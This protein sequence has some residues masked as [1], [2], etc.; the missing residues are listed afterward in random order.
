MVQAM[1]NFTV[2]AVA[3]TLSLVYAS[4]LLAQAP[5][6]S[7]M[8]SAE[9][10]EE[11]QKTI[12]NRM[13][14]MFEEAFKKGNEGDDESLTEDEMV[15]VVFEFTKAQN[16]AMAGGASGTIS[17]PS[18][19]QLNRVKESLRARIKSQFPNVDTDNDGE[20]SKAELFTSMFGREYTPV[21]NGEDDATSSKDEE[22]RRNGD[23]DQ[24]SSED[25]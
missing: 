14:S 2:F 23:T 24:K 16:E 22:T 18:E 9:E 19:E 1:R 20:V 25:D 4:P 8:P 15:D 12:R 6:L 13:K 17:A 11:A 5:P 3:L 7:E 21:E 10:T